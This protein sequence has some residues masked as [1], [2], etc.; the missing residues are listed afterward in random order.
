MK[1]IPVFSAE[2]ELFND[3]DESLRIEC[4]EKLLPRLTKELTVIGFVCGQ[5]TTEISGTRNIHDWKRLPVQGGTFDK[6]KGAVCHILKAAG[7]T[8]AEESFSGPGELHVRLHLTNVSVFD[9]QT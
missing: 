5:P 3:E 7:V 2:I 1:Q 4:S 9:K 6:L 8:I